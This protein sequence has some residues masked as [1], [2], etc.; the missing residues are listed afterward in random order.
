MSCVQSCLPDCDLITLIKAQP[1]CFFST[2]EERTVRR[3]STNMAALDAAL[4]GFTDV[5]TVVEERPEL[6]FKEPRQLQ[7]S[8]DCISDLHLDTISPADVA[9]LVLTFCKP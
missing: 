7:A 4:G 1:A 8:L 6:L 5:A 3:I 2:S 9:V